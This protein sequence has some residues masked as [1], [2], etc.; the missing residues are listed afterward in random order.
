[1]LRL[2]TCNRERGL[3][4]TVPGSKY[5]AP[6]VAWAVG[7][8]FALLTFC[9]PEPVYRLES[10]HLTNSRQMP[11]WA[12]VYIPEPL[13]ASRAPAAIICEPFNSPPEVSRLLALELVKSGFIVM[14]FDWGGLTPATCRA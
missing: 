11:L 6:G 4:V 3:A 2:L 1:V 13:P 5:P 14:T 7:L 8:T 10:V 12:V 9:Y